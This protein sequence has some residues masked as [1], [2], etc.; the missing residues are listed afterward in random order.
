MQK[1]S[2][3]LINTYKIRCFS[4]TSDY[5]AK[6]FQFEENWKAISDEKN[7]ELT[8]NLEKELSEDQK[9]YITALSKAYLNLN[10]YEVT[11]Y[12]EML[13]ERLLKTKC[14]SLLS[15]HMDWPSVKKMGIYI[16]MHIYIYIYYVYR[17][18]EISSS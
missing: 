1:I 6:C 13:K 4:T 12:Y 14:P 3:F 2:K 15:L 7:S 16:Y 18:W 9:N 17:G 11:Y 8:K 5:Q 10:I